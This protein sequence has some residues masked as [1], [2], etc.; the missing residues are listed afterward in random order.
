MRGKRRREE[1]NLSESQWLKVFNLIGSSKMLCIDK[2][3][4]IQFES[5]GV[6]NNYIH[7]IEK[8]IK[9]KLI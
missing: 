6:I 3:P 2:T 9:H 5:G 4:A 8:K 1:K 7:T